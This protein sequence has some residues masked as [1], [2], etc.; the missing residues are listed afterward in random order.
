MTLVQKDIKMK[1]NSNMRFAIVCYLSEKPF[2][3][4]QNTITIMTTT[5][6]P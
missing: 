1:A 6:I 3:Q 5:A 2:F 4:F